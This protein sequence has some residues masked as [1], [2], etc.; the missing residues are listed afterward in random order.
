MTT[1]FVLVHGAMHGAW[2]WLDTA[3]NP[4][5]SAPDELVR[6]LTRVG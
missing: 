4:M 2:C 5:L 1:E 6:L 3:H